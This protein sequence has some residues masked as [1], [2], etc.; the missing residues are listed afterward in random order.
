MVARELQRGAKL[1]IAENPTWGVDIGAIGIIHRELMSM[2]DAGNAV[3]LVS[4]EL[5]EVISLADRIL[6]MSG[7]QQ[8]GELSRA[9]ATRQSIGRLMIEQSRMSSFA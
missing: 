6:V 2:R 9:D 1:I 4:S 5:D 3:L 8:V 7:G